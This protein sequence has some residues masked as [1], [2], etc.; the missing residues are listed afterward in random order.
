MTLQGRAALIVAGI[1]CW[2]AALQLIVTA[3]LPDR[4]EQS[5][6]MLDD[7]LFAPEVGSFAPPFFAHDLEGNRVSLFEYRGRIVLLNFWATW[8]EPCSLELPELASA[9]QAE[10]T[11]M[12]IAVNSGDSAAAIADWLQANH[13]AHS[14][15][16]AIIADE[17]DRIAR[18]YAVHGRPTTL[19]I[20]PDG[21]I[22]HISYGMITRADLESVLIRIMPRESVSGSSYL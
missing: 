11:R 4:A 13:I 17:A 20:A 21:R 22:A 14:A 19:I 12:L 7:E 1:L 3:G 10:E 16:I 2:V 8:C 9:A 6:L 15:Q 5:A 18:I